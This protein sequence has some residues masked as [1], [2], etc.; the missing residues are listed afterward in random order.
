MDGNGRWATTRGLARLRGHAAGIET[1]R[2]VTE[3]CQTLGVPVVT[4]Y[5]FSTENWQRPREEVAGL[6]NLMRQY[7]QKELKEIITKGVR[8]RFIGDRSSTSRLPADILALMT[9]VEAKTAHNTKITTV[10][11]VNYS[12][13][14]ELVRAAQTLAEQGTAITPESL[15]LALDTAELPAP[16]LI[17]RTGGDQRLSNFLLWQAA[18]AELYFSPVAWPDFGPT[19][20][21]AALASFAQRT[22]KFGALPAAPAAA[23]A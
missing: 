23:A 7:F 5:A 1:V 9:E 19:H 13:R 10:F 11:A 22:R 20:L 4:F 3:E 15:N 18:Y 2:R 12:G 8:V 6:F 14:D 16:D 21:Q 17:I